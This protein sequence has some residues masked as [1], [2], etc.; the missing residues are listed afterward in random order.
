MDFRSLIL[1]LVV[2][3]A[4]GSAAGSTL[5][6][7]VCDG[8]VLKIG[9]F[10]PGTG[11]LELLVEFYGV[12]LDKSATDYFADSFMEHEG[13][14]PKQIVLENVSPEIAECFE[15]GSLL[16]VHYWNASCL[17]PPGSERESYSEVSWSFLEMAT[18]EPCPPLNSPV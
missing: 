16:K 9:R 14:G 8:E 18:E 11:T 17:F 6:D 10:D 12:D 5:V 7:L 2:L 4:A 15:D 13:S 1:F 3:S